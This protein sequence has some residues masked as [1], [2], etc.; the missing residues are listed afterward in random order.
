MIG[1]SNALNAANVIPN[2]GHVI[3]PGSRGVI[4][5]CVTGVPPGTAGI[6]SFLGGWFRDG[7]QLPVDESCSSGAP[8]ETRGS[9]VS[10][11]YI[12]SND[13]YRCGSSFTTFEEGVYEC[14]SVVGGPGVTQTLTLN[15]YA[16][17]RSEFIYVYIRCFNSYTYF[18]ASPTIDTPS[19]SHINTDAGVSVS[20]TCRSRGS[21]PDSFTWGQDGSTYGSGTTTAETYTSSSA[22][23]RSTYTINRAQS[24]HTGTWT[25][26][27]SNLI[28]SDS[29]SIT[30]QV[31]KY[32]MLCLYVLLCLSCQKMRLC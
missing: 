19:P 7:S 22:V 24:Y 11:G 3:E 28:G 14:V 25:C 20:L 9:S 6:N 31:G 2:N 23:Y 12:G 16:S 30:L 4:A 1:G 10:E 5:R 32:T 13:L 29:A 26:T 17:S 8:V 27:V 15:V 21:V 18:L